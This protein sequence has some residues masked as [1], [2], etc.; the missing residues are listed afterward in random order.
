[1]LIATDRTRVQVVVPLTHDITVTVNT[2]RFLRIYHKSSRQPAAA[3]PITYT[4]SIH[5]MSSSKELH[6]HLLAQ[7]SRLSPTLLATLIKVRSADSRLHVVRAMIQPESQSFFLSEVLL[8]RLNLPRHAQKIEVNGFGNYSHVPAKGY[9]ELELFNS[10]NKKIKLNIVTLILPFIMK[11]EAT[12]QRPSTTWKH[13]EGL[14][15]ADNFC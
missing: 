7:S 5:S 1:M 14:R 13:L 2:I 12:L 3:S 15:V 11:Y 6:I 9:A 4:I 8:T 10:S